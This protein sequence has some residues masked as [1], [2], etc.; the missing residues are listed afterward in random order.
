MKQLFQALA[1]YNRTVNGELMSLLKGLT[2][3]QLTV[4]TMSFYHSI[5]GTFV[6]VMFSDITWLNRY[7]AAY[8]EYKCFRGGPIPLPEESAMEK[9]FEGNY[10]KAF[11]LRA[12]A[13]A[14]LEQFV[15]ELEDVMFTG[16]FKYRNYKGAEV[17]RM[18]WQT[19]LQAFNHQTHHR[20]SI[21]ALLD[22]Q[23]VQND[24]STLLTRI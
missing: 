18:L 1:K 5:Y 19:L 24:Y 17:G 14:I 4:E 21:A 7:Q 16:I 15:S 2:G 11:K 23:G 13:D 3:E 22:L 20:G 10:A 8:P 6:H 12:E 9:E